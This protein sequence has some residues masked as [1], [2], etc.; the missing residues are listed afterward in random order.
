M[1]LDAEVTW[2]KFEI[3][4][5]PVKAAVASQLRSTPEQPQRAGALKAQTCGRQTTRAVIL[6]I[7]FVQFLNLLQLQILF[8]QP[9]KQPLNLILHGLDIP[10]QLARHKHIYI[11]KLVVLL[12]GDVS[13]FT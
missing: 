7:K 13:P 6:L 5:Q 4:S 10:R 11:D 9:S 8:I 2:A 12:C 3:K 1:T